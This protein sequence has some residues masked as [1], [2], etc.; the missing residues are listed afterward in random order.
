[1]IFDIMNTVGGILYECIHTIARAHLQTMVYEFWFG[2]GSLLILG[3][4][5]V[6]AVLGMQYFGLSGDI[7]IRTLASFV[8][9]DVGGLAHSFTHTYTL[10]LTVTLSLA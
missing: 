7:D 3:V 1:M 2:C 5:L 4:I 10:L 9:M 8:S 6:R